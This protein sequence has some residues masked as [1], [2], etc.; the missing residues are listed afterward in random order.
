M[1]SRR[2]QNVELIDFPPDSV[3]FPVKVLDRR[4]VALLEFIAQ[5]SGH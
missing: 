4:R 2:I 1:I 5:E 3:Q